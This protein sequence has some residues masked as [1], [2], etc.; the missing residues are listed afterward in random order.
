MPVLQSIQLSLIR[1]NI[2]ETVIE[3]IKIGYN[4]IFIPVV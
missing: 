4:K 2:N 1:I 3:D